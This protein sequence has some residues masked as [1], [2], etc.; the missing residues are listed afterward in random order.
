MTSHKNPLKNAYKENEKD[1]TICAHQGYF[2]LT[3][4]NIMT[5]Q[6]QVTLVYYSMFTTRLKHSDS[7]DF[8]K[9]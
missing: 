1:G 9:R 4:S 8:N 3:T 7:R 5:D 6:M 2:Q